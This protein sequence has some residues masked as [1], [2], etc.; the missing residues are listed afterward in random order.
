MKIV[1]VGYGVVGRAVD[2]TLSKEYDIVKYDKFID[3]DKFADLVKCNFV[4]ISVLTPFDH[5]RYKV[6]DS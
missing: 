6:M 5:D 2:A 1:I 4:F 3:Y